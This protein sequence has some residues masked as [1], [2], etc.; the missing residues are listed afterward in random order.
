MT[1]TTG[2]LKQSLALIQASCQAYADGM[3]NIPDDEAVVI[4][5]M[6]LAMTLDPALALELIP[7]EILL[8]FAVEAAEYVIENNTQGRPDSQTPAPKSGARG[9]FP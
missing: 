1:I 8:P 2:A 5:G 9:S 3:T 7:A 6:Q 4:A